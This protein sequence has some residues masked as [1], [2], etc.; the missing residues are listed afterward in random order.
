MEIEGH[1]FPEA[2][3]LL[4]QRA[5]V[6]IRR[7][8]PAVRSERNRLYDICEEAAKIF[9]ETL[10]KTSAPKTYLKNRGVLPETEQEFRIGFAPQS[11]DYLLRVL[12][13]KGF[14]PE[15]I[16]K[17]GLAIKSPEGN[18]WYDR[19]R[20]RIMFPVTDANGRVVGFSGRIFE[21]VPTRS[22]VGTP[23]PGHKD[24]SV[25]AKYINTPQ[26]L[27]YDKSRVLYGFDKAKQEI[28]A[29][30]QVVIVEGQMDCVM[31]HQTGVKNAIAVSGTA[32][33]PPQLK[34]IKRLCDTVVSSFDTDEAGESATKRSLALSSQFEFECRVAIIPSGKDPADA[35]LE[36]PQSWIEAVNSAKQV[37]EFYFEKALRIKDPATGIG[38][39][40]IAAMVLP[41]VAELR[42]EVE[43]AHWIKVLA[44]K[45]EVG[46]EVITKELGKNKGALPTSGKVPDQKGRVPQR[47]ELLEERLL[48]LLPLVSAE[49]RTRELAHHHLIFASALNQELFGLL[50]GE[51]SI[52]VTPEFEKE[53]ELLRFK[54]EVLKT[55]LTDVTEEFSLCRREL[56]KISIRGKL[57][58]LGEEISKKEKQGDQ[59]AVMPLLRDFRQLSERLKQFS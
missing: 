5:G 35:I 30:N 4:A 39:K 59:A 38:K 10:A 45:L 41:W 33:T 42:N 15:D 27:V 22:A 53:L 56:E 8:D 49:A 18:S 20:S 47:R 48:S 40:E 17:A 55:T 3:K 25:G 24:Q 23:T 12:S 26:T 31:S 16:E 46:E 7:E 13:T 43:K 54:G 28:R 11:W 6:V 34:T 19:F 44:E 21:E 29:K 1:D 58:E 57:L 37:V 32:L 50:G 36:N 2:L 52:T 51:A 14:K 9:V